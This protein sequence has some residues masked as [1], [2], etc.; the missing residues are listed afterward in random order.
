MLIR[1]L[2]IPPRQTNS[3]LGVTRVQG[4]RAGQAVRGLYPY[5]ADD[6]AVLVA[7]FP[8]D[9]HVLAEDQPRQVLLGSLSEGLC[10]LRR[11]DTA[12]AD[13]VLLAVGIEDGYRVAI[14]NANYATGQGVGLSGADQ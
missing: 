8:I 4:H 7:L 11:V 14:G 6:A 5:L 1:I 10:L 9:P 2:A 13:F 3:D 12:E